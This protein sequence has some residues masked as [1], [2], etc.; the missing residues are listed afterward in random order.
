MSLYNKHCYLLVK[1]LDR[2]VCFRKIIFFSL[3]VWELNSTKLVKK[4]ERI[5]SKTLY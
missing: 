5:N 4:V 1:K 2:I 3:H